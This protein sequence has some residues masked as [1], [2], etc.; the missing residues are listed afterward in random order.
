MYN[1]FNSIDCTANYP[2]VIGSGFCTDDLNNQGC[3]FDGGDCCGSNVDTTYCLKCICIEDLNCTAPLD[4]IGNGCVHVL[5][6][7]SLSILFIHG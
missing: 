4:L 3:L 1:E 7:L 5:Y 2:G 6:L